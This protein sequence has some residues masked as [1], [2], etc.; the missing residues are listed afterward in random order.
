MKDNSH[1]DLRTSHIQFLGK[2]SQY[3]EEHSENKILL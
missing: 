3:K 1:M 2:G